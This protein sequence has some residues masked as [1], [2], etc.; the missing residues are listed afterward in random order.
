M[1]FG[2]VGLRTYLYF[3]VVVEYILRACHPCYRFAIDLLQLSVYLVPIIVGHWKVDLLLSVLPGRASNPVKTPSFG[4]ECGRMEATYSL[5][6]ELIRPYSFPVRSS[7]M[8]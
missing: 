2:H 8:P 6:K 1:K 3:R 7:A 5:A 4:S